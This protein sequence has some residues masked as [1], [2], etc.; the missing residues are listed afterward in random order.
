LFAYVAS[1]NVERRDKND[2]TDDGRYSAF[3][4]NIESDDEDF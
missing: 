2:A 3:E 1:L 4:E